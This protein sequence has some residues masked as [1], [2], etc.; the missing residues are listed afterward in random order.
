[1]ETTVMIDEKEVVLK[2][3]GFTPI[4]YK[5]HFKE[6]LFNA[7]IKAI[8]G[9]EMVLKSFDTETTEEERSLKLLEGLDMTFFYQLLWVNARSADKNIGDLETWL[10]QFSNVPILE[11]IEVLIDLNFSNLE[12]TKKK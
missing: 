10:G 11:L 9:Y 8:G 4:L 3:T 12:G 1:M 6:D 2:A 7:L 5:Q